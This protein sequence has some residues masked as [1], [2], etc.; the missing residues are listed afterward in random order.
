MKISVKCDDFVVSISDRTALVGAMKLIATDLWMVEIVRLDVV[1]PGN[2]SQLNKRPVYVNRLFQSKQQPEFRFDDASE[3]E[4]DDAEL[5]SFTIRNF[6]AII[7]S[8][9]S[10]PDGTISKE[11]IYVEWESPGRGSIHVRS[12]PLFRRETHSIE[13]V[14]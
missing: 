11:E 7:D 12:E 4:E 6:D 10:L 1:P 8:T 2:S 9:R 13:D 3:F 5:L 14:H